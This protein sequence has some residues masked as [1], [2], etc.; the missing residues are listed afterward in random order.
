VE[1][2]GTLEADHLTANWCWP[3][4][5]SGRVTKRSSCVDSG[6]FGPVVPVHARVRWTRSPGA[7]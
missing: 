5:P 3:R 4:S 6:P 2:A 1:V 7:V